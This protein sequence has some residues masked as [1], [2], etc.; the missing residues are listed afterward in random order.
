MEIAKL[1]V[2][3]N[4]VMVQESLQLGSPGASV[5][6]FST[7]LFLSTP[8]STELLVLSQGQNLKGEAVAG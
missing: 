3:K 4:T 6:A 8:E 7:T 2:M 1:E 5:A